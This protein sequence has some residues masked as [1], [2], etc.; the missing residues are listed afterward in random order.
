MGEKVFIN[1]SN[2]PSEKWCGAQRQEAEKYGTIVDIPFPEVDPVCTTEQVQALAEQICEKIDP[3][4]AAAVMC[5]GEFT[6]TYAIVS[7]LKKKG[8][9]ALAA[10]SRR[11]TEETVKEDGSIQKKVI[12]DFEGFR[13]F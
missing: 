6:L 8:V 9:I 12:F 2:H 10:C 5:Q 1:C 7:R 11:K 3:Y 4:N 13:E